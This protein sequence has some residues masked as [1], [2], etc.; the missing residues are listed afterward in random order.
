L[1]RDFNRQLIEQALE[2]ANIQYLDGELENP[3]RLLTD[4]QVSSAESARV[5]RRLERYGLYVDALKTTSSR[6]KQ[7]EVI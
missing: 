2:E 5:Q 7:F 4:D 1:A 3:Y 6:I